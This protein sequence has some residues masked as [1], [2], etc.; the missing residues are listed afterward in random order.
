[1][2]S[3]GSFL[4]VIFFACEA[5]AV[6]GV[7]EIS[8]ACAENTGCFSGDAASFPVTIDGTAGRSYRL[9]SDLVI[10]DEGTDGIEVSAPSVQIDMNGFQIVRLGCVGQIDSCFSPG[11][12]VGIGVTDPSV[13]G[14][15]VRNG[16][17][18]GMGSDGVSLGDQGEAHAVSARWNGGAGIRVTDSGMITRSSS[19]QNSFG[20]RAGDASIVSESVVTFTSISTGVSVGENGVVTGNTISGSFGGGILTGDNVSVTGNVVKDNGDGIV[21]GDGCTIEGNA[22]SNNNSAGIRTGD[23]SRVQR[24][25]VDFCL[26]CITFTGDGGYGD[27]SVSGNVSGGTN[28]GGNTCGAVVCP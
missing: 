28:M 23:I 21:T 10:P 2:R 26:T 22:V 18:I 15:V 4:L 5:W 27:N 14:V 19:Y 11:S 13:F 1:M 6:D 9:T 16:S 20:L 12:G 24:N 17:V 8:Q 25:T 3:I 7:L